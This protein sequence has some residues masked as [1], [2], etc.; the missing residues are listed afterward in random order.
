MK[1]EKA[2]LSQRLDKAAAIASAETHERQ[3]AEEMIEEMKAGFREL[4]RV[5]GDL[6]PEIVSLYRI[7]DREG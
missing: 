2:V 3:K 4:E 6:P 5:F 1:K 7:P